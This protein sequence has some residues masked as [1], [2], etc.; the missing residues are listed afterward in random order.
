MKIK[1]EIWQ[2]FFLALLT[3]N[4]LCFISYAIAKGRFLLSPLAIVLTSILFAGFMTV[5]KHKVAGEE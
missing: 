3:W 4:G 5:I 1:K 2:D